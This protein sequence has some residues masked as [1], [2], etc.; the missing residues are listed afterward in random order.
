[1][2]IS[3]KDKRVLITAGG[4]GICRTVAEAFINEGAKVHV[5]DLDQA[6]LKD[7]KD[8]YP[9]VEI[10]IC[11]VSDPEQVTELFEDSDRTLGGLDI[12]INGAGI[13]GPA[14]T[15]DKLGVEEWNQTIAVNL[16]GTFYCSRLAVPRIKEAGQGSIINFSST[17]GFL[18][19]AMRSPYAAAKWG[20]IGF[21]KSLALELG[22]DNIRVNAVCPGV[23]EGERMDRV[24]QKEATFKRIS[25]EEVRKNYTK[26]N[27]LR[28]FVSPED[29]AFE[30]IF[31]CSDHG[32]KITGQ[33][34]AVDGFTESNE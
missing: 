5:C 1:M 15:V 21:T 20:I 19:Y 23:V 27:A 30:I 10:S 32:S 18:A 22:Q 11:N 24:I 17:A 7:F 13:G 12:L 34:L 25:E 31:L 9:D 4:A 33:A 8:S 3:V 29:I 28:T 2:E 6:A 16:N 26:G 14:G